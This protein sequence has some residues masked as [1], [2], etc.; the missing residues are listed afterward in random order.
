MLAMSLHD[1]PRLRR[2]II[3]PKNP[4]KAAY[5]SITVMFSMQSAMTGAREKGD[6]GVFDRERASVDT[7]RAG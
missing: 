6:D 7:G 3:C 4:A 2:S 5:H 1:W